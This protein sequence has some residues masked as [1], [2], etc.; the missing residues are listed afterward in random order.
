MFESIKEKSQE[1][2]IFSSQQPQLHAHCDCTHSNSSNMNDSENFNLFERFILFATFGGFMLTSMIPIEIFIENEAFPLKTTFSS[3]SSN[4]IGGSSGYGTPHGLTTETAEKAAATLATT[5]DG[6]TS[7]FSYNLKTTA[8]VSLKIQQIDWWMAAVPSFLLVTTI[9]WKSYLTKMTSMD[10]HGAIASLWILLESKF[11]LK[12]ILTLVKFF[13]AHLWIEN[14][15]D[16]HWHIY[17]T[18]FI[19]IYYCA[20]FM[21]LSY[22]LINMHNNAANRELY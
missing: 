2:I 14:S 10:M 11:L 22:E 4:N 13:Y 17:L 19:L 8:H 9:M 7:F 5:I 1:N 3:S 15:V 12:S 6:L 18:G 20:I 21:H 16:I